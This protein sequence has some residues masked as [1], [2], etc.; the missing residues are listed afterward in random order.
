MSDTM[1]LVPAVAVGPEMSLSATTPTEMVD[2]QRGLIE[3]CRRKILAVKAEAEELLAAYKSAKE[4]KWKVSTLRRH[5][6]LAE[7]RVEYYS[8]I[9]AALE[10][11]FIL[12]PNFPVTMFAIRTTQEEPASLFR[13]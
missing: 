11:G 10:Q 8:K 4:K 7:R 12:V 2:C 13:V 1:Q 6:T 9:K 3:W 5:A